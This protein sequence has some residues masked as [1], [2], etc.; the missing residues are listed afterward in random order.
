MTDMNDAEK[1]MND[2]AKD[3]LQAL[4]NGVPGLFEASDDVQY[5]VAEVLEHLYQKGL[6]DGISLAHL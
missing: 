6:N 5:F 2:A 3:A 4:N 1:D